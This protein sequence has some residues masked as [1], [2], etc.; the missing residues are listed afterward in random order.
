M[1]SPT[2][3][4]PSPDNEILGQLILALESA[5][6]PDS[7]IADFAQRHP[8]LADQ[9]R[10]V[11]ATERLIAC[12]APA[13]P[14]ARLEPGQCLG[15]F[16][17]KRFL[18][19]GGMGEIYEAVQLDLKRSVALKVLRPDKTDER[20]RARF[21]REREVLAK[22]HQTHIVPVFASGEENGLQYIAMQFIEG[23][24]LGH[25]VSALRRGDTLLAGTTK[26]SL[27]TLAKAIHDSEQKAGD[28]RLTGPTE[29]NA[30]GLAGKLSPVPGPAPLSPVRG[31]AP[32]SPLPGFAGRGK[33]EG[34]SPGTGENLSPDPFPKRGGEEAS[35]PSRFGK[36]AGGIGSSLTPDYFHSV[37]ATLADAA[38]ALQAAHDRGICHRD[39][40]PANVMIEPSGKCWLID[41]G[42]ATQC[43]QP[44]PRV[45]QSHSRRESATIADGALT[46]DWLGTPAYMAPEQFALQGDEKLW[47]VWALGATLYELLTTYAP[48]GDGTDPTKRITQSPKSPRTIIRNIPRDLNAICMKAMCLEPSER[49]QSAVDFADDLRRWLTGNSTIARPAWLT[50][51]P[52]RLWARRNKAWAATIFFC[53]AMIT[54]TVVGLR[55]IDDLRVERANERVAFAGEQ[56]TAAEKLSA[57]KQR[58]LDLMEL[59]RLRLGDLRNGWSTQIWEKAKAIAQTDP[60]VGLSDHAAATLSGLDAT[61]VF[62][63]SFPG[64]SSVAFDASGKRLLAGGWTPQDPKLEPQPAR[65][66]NDWSNRQDDVVKSKHV[67]TGPV[68]FDRNNRPLQL[69]PPVSDGQSLVLWDLDRQ[70][71]VAEFPLALPKGEQIRALALSANGEYAAAVVGAARGEATV[72]VWAVKTQKKLDEWHHRAQALTFSPDGALLATGGESGEI[73]V[74]SVPTMEVVARLQDASNYLLSLAFGRHVRRTRRGQG[75]EELRGL[76]LAAGGKGGA[77]S[78]WDLETQNTVNQFQ[79]SYF[80]IYATAISPDGATLASAGRDGMRFWD[81]ATGRRLLHCLSMTWE[82][83]VTFSF[84]GRRIAVTGRSAYAARGGTQIWEWEDGRG[85]KTL[86]GLYGQVAKVIISPNKEFVG[87]LSHSWQIAVWRASTGEL[88]H[89]LDAPKGG[90]ADNA[91]LAFNLDGTRLAFSTSRVAVVW[92]LTNGGVSQTWDLPVALGDQIGFHPSGKLFCFRVESKSQ[93]ASSG[94]FV[95][96]VGRIWQLNENNGRTLVRELDGFERGLIDSAAT[97]DAR[98]FAAASLGTRNNER[99][100][101][102]RVFDGS[103]GAVLFSDANKSGLFGRISIDAAGTHLAISYPVDQSR[104]IELSSG[105]SITARRAEAAI[106]PMFKYL[107]VQE[108]GASAGGV[109]LYRWNESTRLVTLN[110]DVK[111]SSGLDSFSAD[112][113]LL[114]WGNADG[115]V[116]VC[117]IEEVQRRL[118][119]IRLGW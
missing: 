92:N 57:A 55:R 28:V 65:L 95:P 38:D 85:V 67:G 39:L 54:G 41:F 76:L 105:K 66:W 64:A 84:D 42:L 13:P 68:T 1:T 12:A 19:A 77:L 83:G 72:R 81:V 98:F 100:D 69:V 75:P 59:Q 52:V 10:S 119:T 5:A 34:R 51:R 94:L 111:A 40:K 18:T 82:L 21:I 93:P 58:E 26:L 108:R 31:P 87:A 60:D 46:Q 117:D 11:A 106:E 15:P 9:I 103:T 3:S 24:S 6:N 101:Y 4:L 97:Q 70:R 74:R 115:T 20:R 113:S 71:S 79:G 91:G 61:R 25:V 102:A 96:N 43:G 30:C 109:S 47:D 44:A 48:Y 50:L 32:L 7:V 56:A 2:V 63:K 86:R 80:D 53:V 35:P 22:L 110:L 14:P 36:G 37:A 23:A 118:A 78:V 104:V 116:S 45:V 88:L 114:A 49:Y 99:V 90:Y 62:E 89:I 73:V 107:S 112:G 29:S 17:I 33:G 8:Q 16:R 27:A